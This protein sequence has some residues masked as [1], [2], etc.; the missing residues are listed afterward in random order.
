MSKLYPVGKFA[1][2][3]GVSKQALRRMHANGELM[4]E[5]ISDGGTR[6]YSEDQLNHFKRNKKSLENGYVVQGLKDLKELLVSRDPNLLSMLTNYFEVDWAQIIAK[7]EGMSE[8]EK[9][10][11]FDMETL[12]REYT[13]EDI[14]NQAIEIL[15]K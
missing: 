6:Y 13:F 4:P 11:P 14:I 12:K 9:K 15:S 1:D 10:Q 7:Y 8:E 2:L 5:Y 3:A